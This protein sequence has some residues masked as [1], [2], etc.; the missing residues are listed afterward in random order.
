MRPHKICNPMGIRHDAEPAMLWVPSSM[1]SLMKILYGGQA[2]IY[3][4]KGANTHPMKI[5]T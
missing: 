5:C 2:V 1:Q 4:I 3:S